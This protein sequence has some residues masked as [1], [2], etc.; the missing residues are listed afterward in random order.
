[1]YKKSLVLL[2]SLLFAGVSATVF[3]EVNEPTKAEKFEHADKN[4]DGAVDKKEM[5]MEKNWEQ[6]K[7]AENRSLVNSPVEKRYDRDGNGWLDSKETK[8]LLKD[9]YTIIQTDGKAKVNTAIETKYDANKDGVID[10]AE[11]E[12]M[13]T[14]M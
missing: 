14:D 1:M 5:H 6:N 11:A 7:A 13:Q 12:A 9:K 3:A 10:A 4:D 8:A 2:L